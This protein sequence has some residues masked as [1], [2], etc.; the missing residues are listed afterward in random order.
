MRP[1]V[2]VAA[3]LSA[4]GEVVHPG[5]AEHGVVDAVTFEAAV[6]EDLPGLHPGEGVLDAGPDLLVRAVVLFF[7]V[8]EFGLAA[9]PAVRDDESGALVTA[10]GDRGRIADGVPGAGFLPATGVVPVARQRSADHDD[11]AGV[12]V[13]DDLVGGGVAVVLGLHGDRM[14][15]GG[16]Q[17]AV[18]DKHGVLGETLAGLEREH[19][20]E[21]A[22]DAVRRRLRYPEQRSEL[23]HRQVRAP[24]RCDQQSPVFQRQAP[25]PTLAD[26]VRTL[27]PQKRHELAEA[28]RAQPR[29]RGYPG[30]LRCRDHTTHSTTNAPRHQQLRDSP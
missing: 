4:E 30:T 25:G 16:H 27:A 7:P 24:V 9:L 26:C 29:E 22:D 10:V 15:T 12:R 23:P 11:E 14:I 18:H 13:D 20:P 21:V 28:A 8:R 19:R 2:A 6:A 3:R 17:R 5:D 1:V